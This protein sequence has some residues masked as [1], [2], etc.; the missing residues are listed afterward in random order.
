MYRDSTSKSGG[1]LQMSSSNLLA[2]SQVFPSIRR[3]ASNCNFIRRE[4]GTKGRRGFTNSTLV[5]LILRV[6]RV[7]PSAADILLK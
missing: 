4:F 5:N 6:V 3:L 7:L 2:L 1:H